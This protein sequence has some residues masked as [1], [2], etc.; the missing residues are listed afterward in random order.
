MYLLVPPF[1]V[2]F[3]P[4]DAPRKTDSGTWMPL[5]GA[6][7]AIAHYG[8]DCGHE[9]RSETVLE[10]FDDRFSGTRPSFK[11]RLR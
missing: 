6:T 8:G 10:S 3:E 1:A 9:R 2:A 4:E 5:A 11:I 7:N